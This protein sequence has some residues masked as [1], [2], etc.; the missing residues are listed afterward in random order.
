MIIKRKTESMN[1]VRYGTVESG[2]WYPD[3]VQNITNFVKTG[4]LT[5]LLQS[6]D[7]EIP[8]LYLYV[9]GDSYLPEVKLG[10]WV[11]QK[12]AGSFSRVSHEQFVNDFE[13]VEV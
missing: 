4:I 1:A 13:V 12:M 2:E 6:C 5:T 3:A 7:K 10:D 11:V 9:E 8:T